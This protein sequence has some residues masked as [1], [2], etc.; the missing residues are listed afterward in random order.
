MAARQLLPTLE[1]TVRRVRLDDEYAV[2]QAAG[3]EQD[4]SALLA[5][6]HAAAG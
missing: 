4:V 2:G 5:G 1:A 6:G 3:L